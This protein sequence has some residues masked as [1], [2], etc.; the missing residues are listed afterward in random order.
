MRYSHSIYTTV[1]PS[2]KSRIGV[3]STAVIS[4]GV[5]PLRIGLRHWAFIALADNV[6][7]RVVIEIKRY[8]IAILSR[9]N[10]G[11]MSFC[12]ITHLILKCFVRFINSMV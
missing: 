2:S 7:D 3:R 11:L 10:Y 6:M 5:T 8:F 12:N 1:R 9:L 4:Y